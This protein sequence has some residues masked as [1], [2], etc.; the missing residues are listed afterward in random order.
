[1]FCDVRIREHKMLE[2]FINSPVKVAKAMNNMFSP[3]GNNS[4][5]KRKSEHQCSAEADENVPPLNLDNIKKNKNKADTEDECK[6]VKFTSTATLNNNKQTKTCGGSALP[7]YN[8]TR[9]RSNSSQSTSASTC[10]SSKSYDH[11]FFSSQPSSPRNND[12]PANF[13]SVSSLCTTKLQSDGLVKRIQ[14]VAAPNSAQG[15]IR[16]YFEGAFNSRIEDISNILTVKNKNKWDWK[17]KI[18]KQEEAVKEGKE[19]L[20]Q[21]KEDMEELKISCLNHESRINAVLIDCMEHLREKDL[22]L[23]EISSNFNNTIIQL[24]DAKS[25]LAEVEKKYNKLKTDSE[26]QKQQLDVLKQQIDGYQSNITKLE[27]KL[28]ETQN[29]KN[30]IENE[31]REKLAHY[32]LIN[33]QM[34]LQHQSVR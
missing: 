15:I 19:M 6:K 20:N 2:N 33:E 29:E 12:K 18:K 27:T 8:S 28:N 9:T 31:Y 26:P 17:D 4:S 7:R 5:S 30:R 34:K 24:S 11:H 22:E 23:N 1:M 3:G 25:Q 13:K 14:E 10:S 32:E 16:G 21:Y